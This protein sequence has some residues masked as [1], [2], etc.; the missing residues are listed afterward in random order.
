MVKKMKSI[1]NFPHLT[2]WKPYFFVMTHGS[3]SVKE[4][5]MLRSSC[6]KILTNVEERDPD[7][8]IKL[9]NSIGNIEHEI[10][11]T[12]VV[13]EIILDLMKHAREEK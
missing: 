13:R 2:P 9:L 3:I 5:D 11:T 12:L 6:Q 8:A 10:E 1:T 7:K 4:L